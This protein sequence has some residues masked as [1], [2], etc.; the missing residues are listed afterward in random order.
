[1]DQWATKDNAF[2][3]Y[4]ER[5]CGK[6][7]PPEPG[8]FSEELSLLGRYLVTFQDEVCSTGPPLELIHTPAAKYG[9]G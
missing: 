2:G 3:G 9:D 7:S 5:A 4:K 1:M 6:S 8:E